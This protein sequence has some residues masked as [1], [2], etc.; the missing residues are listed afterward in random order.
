MS[1]GALPARR[2]EVSDRE[3]YGPR[4][5]IG[6]AESL[7]RLFFDIMQST[8]IRWRETCVFFDIPPRSQPLRGREPRG[9]DLGRET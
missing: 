8:S 7:G 3:P 9:G 1:V 6:V 2:F 4:Y 5:Q